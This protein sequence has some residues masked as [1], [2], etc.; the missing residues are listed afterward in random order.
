MSPYVERLWAAAPIAQDPNPL[1]SL[2]TQTTRSWSDANLDYVP[3]CNLTNP[4]ANGECGAMANAN[5][6]LPV[7]GAI[8]DDD[9]MHGFGKRGYNWEF[10]TGVQHE[11]LPRT[12]VDVSYFRRTY[13]NFRV[14]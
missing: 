11:I 2:I 6:G 4:A 14:T 10:S 9:L 1:S 7:P 5:F 12:S 13:G 3:D 8:F